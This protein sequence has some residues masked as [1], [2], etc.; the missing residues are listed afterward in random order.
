MSRDTFAK[1]TCESRPATGPNGENAEVSIHMEGSTN[2]LLN[3]WA[4]M[5]IKLFENIFEIEGKEDGLGLYATVQADVL[6]ELGVDP[7]E[8]AKKEL[9][10]M[11]ARLALESI[12]GKTF[13]MPQKG[14]A[15]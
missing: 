1:L 7:E 8:E 4:Q 6:K 2:S 5:T 12:L 11:R 15:E 13:E 9:Q 14:D 3:A 10:K